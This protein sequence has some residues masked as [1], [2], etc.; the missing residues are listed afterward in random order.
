MEQGKETDKPVKLAFL[1]SYAG[2]GFYGSQVQPDVRTVEGEIILACEK[3]SLFPDNDSGHLLM[4]GRTDR[5]V[6]AR[7]QIITFTT[8]Y[9]QRAIQVLNNL[10]P[11]DIRFD[12]Y[13]FVDSKFHPR[14]SPHF[15]TYRYYGISP[16]PDPLCMGKAASL[17]VG[18]HTYQ[19]FAKME[20][21]RDPVRTVFDSL[22]VSQDTGWYYEI[23]AESF[24]W[25]MVRGIVTTLLMYQDGLI[26]PEQIAL[27]LQG[28]CQMRIPPADP[29]GLILWDVDCNLDW[30][31]LPVS[32]KAE[33]WRISSIEHHR[34][35]ACMHQVM[36]P[37][38]RF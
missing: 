19:C 30:I 21:G 22:F 32:K 4:S 2:S 28:T 27:M 15:R 25:H 13:S 35:M 18:T 12:A 8:P 37:E 16:V 9:P 11:P 33:Q 3:A 6:H 31:P 23:R 17:F 1:I 34:L 20:P 29:Q 38:K 36:A 26:T 14:Y 5:G 24:L 7:R 10:L